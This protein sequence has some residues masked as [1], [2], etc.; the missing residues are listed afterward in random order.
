MHF[1]ICA[2]GAAMS[3]IRKYMKYN[4]LLYVILGSVVMTD[5]KANIIEDGQLSLT[6]RNFYFDRDFDNPKINTFGS[7]SQGAN[8]IFESGYTNTPIQV[9][10]DASVRDAVR[11][12]NHHDQTPDL[13]FPYD[14]SKGELDRNYAKYG[15]T[16]KFKYENTEVKVGE[17][18]PRTPIVYFDDS[19]QLVTSFAG[20]MLENK[21]IKNLKISAGRITH[22]NA[23]NN[24]KYEKLS[25]QGFS[26]DR[27]SNGLNFIGFDYNVNPNFLASYWFGQLENIYQQ[28]YIGASY[29]AELNDTKLKFDGSY[30]Y[31]SEDG[32]AYDGV[33]DS[34]ALGSMVTVQNG[35]STFT[36]GVQKNFGDSAF[37]LLN[38]FAPQPYLLAW[39]ILPFNSPE[40]LIIFSSYLYDF[41]NLGFP[42]LKTRFSYHHGDNIKRVGLDDN[43]EIER[44]FSLIYNVPEGRLKGLSFEWRYTEADFKYAAAYAPGNDFKENRLITSYS[45]KF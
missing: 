39:S 25:L 29:K 8:L 18:L 33:I 37:P 26:P 42:G 24:D 14:Q 15:V 4:Y 23:R 44:V 20:V 10:F 2:Q 32:D 17:L 3:K 16:L 5:L 12:N 27:T 45:F 19:R 28:N 36:A 41:K 22:I 30:F 6:L 35:A 21:D 13:I 1:L 40:E 34:Q 7:W 31:N 38:G 11:L 43:K 9:G